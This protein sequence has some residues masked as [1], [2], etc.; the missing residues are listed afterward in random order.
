MVQLKNNDAR[1]KSGMLHDTIIITL[2][3]LQNAVKWICNNL[4]HVMTLTIRINFQALT[5]LPKLKFS[6]YNLARLYASLRLALRAYM[7]YHTK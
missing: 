7:R 4:N 5:T 6:C 3:V 2:Q 1:N